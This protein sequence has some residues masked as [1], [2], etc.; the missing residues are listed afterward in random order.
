MNT[1]AR[2][3]P[4]FTIVIAGFALYQLFV[5]LMLAA[6]GEWAFAL[7]YGV[8]SFAGWALARVLWV[9]KRKMSQSRE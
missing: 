5:A 2:L 3:L 6:R 7:F 9:N 4:V 8:M 1:F